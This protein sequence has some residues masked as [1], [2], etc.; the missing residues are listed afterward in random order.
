PLDDRGWRQTEGL[1][2][3]LADYPIDRLV[4]SGHL[5]CIQ[6]LEPLAAERGLPIEE[7]RELQEGATREE[8]LALMAEL[9]D[10][11]A[12]CT[13]GDVLQELFGEAG[14]K[15]ATRVV[16]LRDGEPAVL[17]YLAPPA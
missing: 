16:E 3:T 2:E 6:T 1:V 14:R 7:R 5:R 8:A 12:L 10:R 11:A 15:G 4:S 13:H 17:E 9:G